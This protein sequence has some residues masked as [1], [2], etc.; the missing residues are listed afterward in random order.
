MAESRERH[1]WKHCTHPCSIVHPLL[2]NIHRNSFECMYCYAVMC[3]TIIGEHLH[4][5]ERGF[6]S[7]LGCGALSPS[8]LKTD[9]LSLLWHSGLKSKTELF[10]ETL[11]PI[12]WGLPPNSIHKGKKHTFNYLSHVHLHTKCDLF[13]SRWSPTSSSPWWPTCSEWPCSSS[14]SSTTTFRPIIQRPIDWGNG[15]NTLIKHDCI[16]MAEHN[17]RL[18]CVWVLSCFSSVL[19]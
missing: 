5:H 19:K 6:Q 11:S 3:L 12:F 2:L 17:V 4:S 7:A 16:Y 8:Q 1:C 15:T 9:A 18:V 14:S 13:H 10:V